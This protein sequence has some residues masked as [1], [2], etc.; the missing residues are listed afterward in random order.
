MNGEASAI[1]HYLLGQA[2]DALTDTLPGVSVAVSRI[3]QCA[4][5]DARWTNGRQTHC[6]RGALLAGWRQDH[7]MARAAIER[8]VRATTR[9]YE[10]TK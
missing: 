8:W 10:E 1:S 7:T 4:Y 5:L 3:G 6:T 9:Y 2:I